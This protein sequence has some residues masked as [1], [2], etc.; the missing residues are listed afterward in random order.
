[1]LLPS[2]LVNVG[3]HLTRFACVNLAIIFCAINV[4]I[5]NDGVA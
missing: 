3:V 4:R 1:V 5:Y 2:M